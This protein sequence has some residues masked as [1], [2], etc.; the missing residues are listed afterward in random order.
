MKNNAVAGRMHGKILRI[1]QK[2]SLFILL[3]L[4]FGMIKM[5]AYSQKKLSFKL[6]K[7]AIIPRDSSKEKGKKFGGISAIEY[8]NEDS[9]LVVSDHD[10]DGYSY[11]FTINT[12]NRVLAVNRF[13]DLQCIEAIR[14]NKRMHKLF[15]AFEKG[16]STGVGY[17]EDEKPVT[18]FTE[19][20]P[21]ANTTTNR[22]I[23]GITFSKDNSLW[24]SFES[25]GSKDCENSTIPFYRFKPTGKNYAAG[26][27]TVYEYPFVRCSCSRGN[28]NGALG[29]GVS[30]IL[31][32]KDDPNKMLVLE[33]C[34]NGFQLHVLL[35][36][37]TVPKTGRKLKKELVFNFNKDNILDEIRNHFIPDNLEGMT[38]GKN[39]NGKRTLY[40]ISDN[41]FNMLQRNQVVKLIE[42]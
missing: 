27:K 29:N 39:E 37:V 18:I 9:I 38:W 7:Q 16:K 33:R 26:K 32:F 12:Y 25:G 3:L 13:Y 11:I 23:E 20:I 22:G 19:P 41:N 31:A 10:A 42:E 36:L 14:Y 1:N 35:Y 6:E 30:E 28:F 15:Y 4:T 24:V 40:L 21:S 34:F 2:S 8:F 17:I 5:P